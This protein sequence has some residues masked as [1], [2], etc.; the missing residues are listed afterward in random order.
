MDSTGVQSASEMLRQL[1]DYTGLF[2]PTT[3]MWKSVQQ[4]SYVVTSVPYV[5]HDYRRYCHSLAYNRRLLRHFAILSY[6]FYWYD[7]LL[8]CCVVQWQCMYG[9]YCVAL[10]APFLCRCIS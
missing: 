8:M 7:K 5:K 3:M 10:H 1:F 9:Y 2:D 6:G 4:L